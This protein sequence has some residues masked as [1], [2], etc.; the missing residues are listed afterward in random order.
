MW[1]TQWAKWEERFEKARDFCHG[2]GPPHFLSAGATSCSG[3]PCSPGL[4]GKSGME[5]S[6]TRTQP[7]TYVE[8]MI[9]LDGELEW[10]LICC[11]CMP[12]T[13]VSVGRGDSV[14]WRALLA[15][16]CWILLSLR[17]LGSLLQLERGFEW[18]LGM[19]GPGLCMTAPFF[20]SICF[21]SR[22]KS[23]CFDESRDIL[24]FFFHLTQIGYEGTEGWGFQSDGQA[25][26]ER[27][28]CEAV[29]WESSTKIW[30]SIWP[31]TALLLLSSSL[32]CVAAFSVLSN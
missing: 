23:H 14:V 13:H 1:W 9:G 11:L 31:S 16:P 25:T 32:A 27:R 28:L 4:Y 12:E 30:V 3:S 20:L 29:Q 19:E 22:P 17:G 24:L 26:E 8:I 7:I 10:E 15:V 5:R 18:V 6:C 21:A 2:A